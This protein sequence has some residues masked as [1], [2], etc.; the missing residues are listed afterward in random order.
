M[1]VYLTYIKV[2]E[3]TIFPL[4]KKVG[5]LVSLN[6]IFFSQGLVKVT[7]TSLFKFLMDILHWKSNHFL[8]EKVCGGFLTCNA[9]LAAE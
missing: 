5:M 4:G 1:A 3:E 9:E 6:I 2:N 8:C 7:V